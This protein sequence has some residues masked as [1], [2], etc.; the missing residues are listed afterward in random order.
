MNRKSVSNVNN[1][2]L[3]E[4]F[5]QEVRVCWNPDF[6]ITVIWLSFAALIRTWKTRFCSAGGDV[7]VKEACRLCSPWGG[8]CAEGGFSSNGSHKMSFFHLSPKGTAHSNSF[9]YF[10]SF[11][12]KP[13][14][15]MQVSAH[16]KEERR[17]RESPA[18]FVSV[19]LFH[20]L[21]SD[22]SAFICSSRHFSDIVSNFFC[23][24]MIFLVWLF[25]LI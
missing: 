6:R 15:S 7:S 2:F 13:R 20:V 24:K 18:A 21:I 17:E 25:F 12:G 22:L 11:Q 8:L 19:D 23:P 16:C 1:A 5:L 9:S 4:S 10:Y 14:L 3:E